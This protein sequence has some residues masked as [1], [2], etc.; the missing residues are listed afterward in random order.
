ML[1]RKAK[2]QDID[3]ILILLKEVLEIHASIRPD[4]FNHGVTKYTKEELNDMIKDINNP[5]Y[6]A[7]DDNNVL[8]G[9]VFCNTRYPSN[10]HIMK[11]RKTLYIDDFCIKEEYRNKSIG[12]TLFKYI[13]E[14][15]TKL[16]YDDITLTV[17]NNNEPAVKFYEKLGFKV[18][19]KY[20]EFKL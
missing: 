19:M 13:K 17:W 18:R 12:K 14:E 1:I 16:G 6:V 2:Q 3:Q 20:M 15:A 5:I 11:Y 4:I 9:Y 7:V 10:T 8:L